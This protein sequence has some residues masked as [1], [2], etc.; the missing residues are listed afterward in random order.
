MTTN[1]K[2]QTAGLIKTLAR[3]DLVIELW[4][5]PEIE[6]IE[7]DRETENTIRAQ[8]ASGNKWAWCTAVVTAKIDNLPYVGRATLGCCSYPSETDFLTDGY[9]LSMR[10]EA[11][12]DLHAQIAK[13][14]GE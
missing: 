9:Y 7:S 2:P 13:A 6:P 4:A 12:E 5:E 1:R 14:K 10:Q 3:A 8:L 11:I